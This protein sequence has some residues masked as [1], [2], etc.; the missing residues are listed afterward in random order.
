MPSQKKTAHRRKNTPQILAMGLIGA[1]LMVLGAVAMLLLPG[2]P[3]ADPQA[4]AYNSAVPVQVDFPA[5]ELSLTNLDGKP[6]TLADYAGGF[7]LVN[8]WAT[9]CPPCKAEMPTLQAFYQDHQADGFTIIAIEAGEPLAQVAAFV[10]E[11]RLTFP[12]WPDP[13]Q[14]SLNAFRNDGLPNSYLIDP[15][16]QVRL[17]WSGAISR[18]MLDQYVAPL[19]EE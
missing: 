14:K 11:Q 15:Q 4:D 7:V 2:K 19:L 10:Q 13:D 9:W 1:G 16:G 18:K 8:N 12:V 3:A 5:P 6:V 17:A